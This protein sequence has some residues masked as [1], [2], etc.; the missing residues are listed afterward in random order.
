MLHVAIKIRNISSWLNISQAHLSR[1]TKEVVLLKL[2]WG[3]DS[4]PLAFLKSWLRNTS[5]SQSGLRNSMPSTTGWRHS[6]RVRL[7]QMKY[8]PTHSVPHNAQSHLFMQMFF[9]FLGRRKTFD[10]AVLG[11]VAVLKHDSGVV[12]ELTALLGGSQGRA[13]CYLQF[14]VTCQ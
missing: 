1:L 11:A 14:C 10:L 5:S 9:L 8:Y 3:R 12:Q 2:K 7:L 4:S 13:F 6:K